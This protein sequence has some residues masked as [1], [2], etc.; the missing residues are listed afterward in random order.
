M[1]S[2]FGL[3]NSGCEK[4]LSLSLIVL[5]NGLHIGA[6]LDVDAGLSLGAGLVG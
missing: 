3:K 2:D 1:V 5:A 6:R 4:F